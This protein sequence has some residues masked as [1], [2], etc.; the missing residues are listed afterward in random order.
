[1]TSRTTPSQRSGPGSR[2]EPVARAHRTTQTVLVVGSVLALGAALG[3]VW[4]VRAGVVVAV[5]TCIVTCAL[6]WREL[7]AA[8]RRHAHRLLVVDK[9]HGDVL[10]KERTRNAE[11]VDAL[12][13]RLSSAGMVVVGQRST[14]A[15]LRGE[16]GVL[17]TERDGLREQVAERDT[18]IGL[19]RTSLREQEA[20]LLAVRA[21]QS[22][23]A[24]RISAQA[25]AEVHALPRRSRPAGSDK[26]GVLDA[27][28]AE[29]TMV[30]PNYETSRR[31]AV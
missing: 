24:E 18:L 5:A 20:A 2:R 13:E 27:E 6:A 3:P 23:L 14:I 31:R 26:P 25:D 7:S 16:V 22:E 12:S 17:T 1:M 8:R 11:V 21:Q 29:L 15:Q 30:L 9:K 19:F 28:M 10:R 4:L